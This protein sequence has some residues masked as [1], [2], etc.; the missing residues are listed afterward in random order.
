M[1]CNTSIGRLWSNMRK[2]K[3]KRK[4]RLSASFCMTRLGYLRRMWWGSCG[5]HLA[6]KTAT[7]VPPFQT[8]NSS[9][10]YI[11]TI[12]FLLS[13]CVIC[14]ITPIHRIHTLI[15]VYCL[16]TLGKELH[17]CMMP[18]N[19]TIGSTLI[20]DIFDNQAKPL[21]TV[22]LFVCLFSLPIQHVNASACRDPCIV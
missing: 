5:L 4:E 11:F 22:H 12:P 17:P 2:E 1:V 6:T 14:T 9:L 8:C 20:P 21:S 3:G 16:L 7:L 15:H 13:D 10:L 18:C 19:S